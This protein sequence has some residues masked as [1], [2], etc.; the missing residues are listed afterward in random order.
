MKQ[1]KTKK[2]IKVRAKK[3]KDLANV[4]VPYDL[5]KLAMSELYNTVKVTKNIPLS[6][7]DL[8]MAP[9]LNKI[10]DL[11]PNTEVFFSNKLPV[12]FIKL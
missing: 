12:L 5:V 8:S 7:L 4:E 2:Q 10:L 3:A 1:K 9:N 6:K 11:R